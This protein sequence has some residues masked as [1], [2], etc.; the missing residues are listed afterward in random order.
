MAVVGATNGL[1]G[2]SREVVA[3]RV[4]A[5]AGARRDRVDGRITE[6][7][8]GRERAQLG[9]NFRDARAVDHVGL[10]ERDR[11]FSDA[12]QREDI[13]VLARLGH[14]AIVRGDDQ[15]REVDASRAGEHRMDEALV[16]G[17]VD[18]AENIAAGERSVRVAQVDRDAAGLLLR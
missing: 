9:A 15:E 12:E 6:R 2:A 18:E 10:G 13:D 8:A 7:G 5:L 14:D 3:Q 4:D 11:A 1:R 17:D 16:A